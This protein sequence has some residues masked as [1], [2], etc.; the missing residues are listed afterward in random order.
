MFQRNYVPHSASFV[1]WKS[2]VV[3]RNIFARGARNSII[4]V[5]ASSANGAYAWNE[6]VIFSSDPN[7]TPF[8]LSFL[9]PDGSVERRLFP[10]ETWQRTTGFDLNSLYIPTLPRETDVFVLPN[11]YE[12]GR[13]DLVF[14]NW[15]HAPV[16]AV[17]I[18]NV[19]QV[20]QM[21][22]VFNAQNFPGAPVLS[23]RFDGSRIS[24]PQTGLQ[25][26]SSIGF[27]PS[28]STAPEFNVFIL[29]ANPPLPNNPPMIGEVPNLV[30]KMNAISPILFLDVR[31][32]E[33]PLRQLQLSGKSANPDLI[34]DYFIRFGGWANRRAMVLLPAFNRTGATTVTLSLSDGV[35]TTRTEFQVTVTN[36]LE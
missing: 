18:G 10:F 9:L 31:D 21:Y 36:P 28:A 15:R 7:A 5:D 2:L 4:H 25:T 29:R 1:H 11:R 8:A 14:Y 20:G 27:P 24:I 34:P 3:T 6:N 16:A 26:A 32:H 30:L 13:A 17:S 35:F 19:L 22:D 33:T 23:G 12:S